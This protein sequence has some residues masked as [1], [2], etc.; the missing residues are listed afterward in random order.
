MIAQSK[1]VDGPFFI[2]Y[3]NGASSS[4]QLFVMAFGKFFAGCFVRRIGFATKHAGATLT[5]K[6]DMRFTLGKWVVGKC[7]FGVGHLLGV[8]K[9]NN[10]AGVVNTQLFKWFHHCP[11]KTTGIECVVVVDC[12]A[13]EHKA[14]TAIG[15]VQTHSHFCVALVGA[16]AHS[17]PAT[18]L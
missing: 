12:G 17:E 4:D 8:V 13:L 11:G 16:I 2:A 1:T 7:S 9:H 10:F 14:N 18:H 3:A 15:Q 6:G 5:S